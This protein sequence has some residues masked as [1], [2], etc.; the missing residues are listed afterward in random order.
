MTNTS[1][2]NIM[3]F[4]CIIF[5]QKFYSWKCVLKN[6]PKPGNNSLYK[7]IYSTVARDNEK[8]ARPTFTSKAK[9]KWLR[10]PKKYIYT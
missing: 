1:T 7:N 3:W 4:E 2:F 9:K 8:K 6:G 10:K 5:G